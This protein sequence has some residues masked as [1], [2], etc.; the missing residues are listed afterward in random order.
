MTYRHV[1]V[2]AASDGLCVI[3]KGL[4]PADRVVISGLQRVRP[5]MK[6]AAKSVAMTAEESL[7]ADLVE[8]PATSPAAAAEINAVKAVKAANAKPAEEGGP[9]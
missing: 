5:G 9:G 6:V 1:E 8:G 3:E 2:G 4:K 7:G